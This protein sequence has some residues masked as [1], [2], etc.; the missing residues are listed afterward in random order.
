MRTGLADG[1]ARR[2]GPLG[3]VFVAFGERGVSLVDLAG[4]P[5][6]FE[7]AARRR[8]GRPAVPAE[9]PPNLSAA[10]DRAI[11]AGRPGRLA[12]DLGGLSD[13]QAAVLRK[14]AEIPRGEVRPYGWI[15]AEIG[16][17]GAIRAVGSALAANPIP[18]I[19]PCHRVVRADGTLGEYSLGGAG[20][21]PRLLSA[22]GVDVDRLRALSR[23]GI[24]YLGSATTMVFCHPTCRHARRI[25]DRHRVEL[26]SADD[27][28]QAGFRPCRH[29]RPQAA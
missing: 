9:P 5:A 6:R 22:E 29:C 17:P 2:D 7:A 18:L 4:D 25:T 11:A 10:I 19:V 28:E 1:Y 8:L 15:A 24:R 23:R 16:R 20:N 27:A 21:K 13:F 3:P 26:A 14:A 12:L